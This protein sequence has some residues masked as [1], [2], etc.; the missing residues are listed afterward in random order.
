[1]RGLV[2]V[3]AADATMIGTG[4]AIL[5]VPLVVPLMLLTFLAAFVPLI[6]AFSAV[7]RPC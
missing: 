7:W 2:L 1:M 5:G 3:G 4:L 6:G